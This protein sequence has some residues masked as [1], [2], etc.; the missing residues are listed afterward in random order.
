MLSPREN[1][2]RALRHEPTEYTPIATLDAYWG[3]GGIGWLDSGPPEGG[4]DGFGV[5][6][7][8]EDSV[9]MAKM[10]E[11]GAFVLKDITEWKKVVTIPDLDAIDWEKAAETTPAPDPAK[12]GKTSCGWGVFTRLNFLMGFEGALVAMMTEPEAVHEFFDAF[13]EYRI[14]YCEKVVKYFKPDILD[15]FD[16]IAS[17]RSPFISLETYKTMIKPYHKRA[18][19]AIKD[20]GAIPALHIC[21]R[22]EDYV[23]EYIDAGA[24]AWTMVQPRNDIAGILEK[25]AGRLCIWDGYDANGPAGYYGATKE[26]IQNEV[27]RCLNSYGPP[28][29]GYFFDVGAVQYTSEQQDFRAKLQE[30]VVEACLEWRKEEF[31]R[32]GIKQQ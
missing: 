28:L 32:L 15:Y 13:T 14:K 31:E 6:F 4:L 17:E 30:Y 10:P 11:P 19:S 5:N 12:V 22:A 20:L 8:R 7:V 24:Q 23:E 26:T 29:K 25:Y 3:R 16:D 27:R 18:F 1:F 9:G 21:G 2:L